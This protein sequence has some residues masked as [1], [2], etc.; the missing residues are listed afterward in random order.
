MIKLGIIQSCNEFQPT[1]LKLV[2]AMDDPYYDDENKEGYS[3][4]IWF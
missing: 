2:K 1:C 3:G 4:P